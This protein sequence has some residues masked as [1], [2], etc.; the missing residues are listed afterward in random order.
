MWFGALG[1]LLVRSDDGLEVEVG[2]RQR[3][4]L[5]CHLLVD[6]NRVVSADQLIDA[7]W[8]ENPPQA[9]TGSLQAQLSRLRSTLGEGVLKTRPPGYVLTIPD[10][11]FDVTQFEHLTAEGRRAAANRQIEEA[12]EKLGQGLGLWRGDAY[13]E[14]ADLEFARAEAARLQE[15][16]VGALE[17]RISADLGL[18]RHLALVPE[19]EALIDK[20]RFRE[21]F[22][23]RLMLALYRSGRQADA[24]SVYQQTR[25]IL[26]EELGIEPSAELRQ[27]EEQILLQ[28]PVLTGPLAAT[29]SRGPSQTGVT[30]FLFADVQGSTGVLERLGTERY[31]ML[32]DDYRRIVKEAAHSEKGWIVNTEGDGIFCAFGTASSALKAAAI[33]QTAITQHRWP[34][35]VG[36]QVRMGIH[37]GEALETPNDYVS[38]EVHRAARIAQAAWGGQILLSQTTHDLAAEL[39]STGPIRDRELGEHQLKD[40]TVPIRL[41]QLE[42]P[43]LPTDH[44]SPRS[45]QTGRHN[46]PA[47]LTSFIGR[48]QELAELAKLVAGARLVT[49]TGV[50]GSGKTRLALEAAGAAVGEFPDGVKLIQLAPIGSADLVVPAV[51]DSMGVQAQAHQPLIETLAQHVRTKEMLLIV[52]NC[53]HLLKPAADTVKTLLEAAPG[54]RILATSRQRL[55]V[56]GEVTYPLHPMPIPAADIVELKQLMRVEAVALFASRAETAR[57]GFRITTDNASAIKEICRH[58]DGIPLAI[59]LAAGRLGSL[60]PQKIA[61]HLDQR[62]RI[63]TVADRTAP[64][65]QQTLRATID[66][67]YQLLSQTEQTLFS[68]LSIFRGSFP[69]EAAEE[70][71]KDTQLSPLD[72]VDL[73]PALAENSLVTVDHTP[74]ATRY[75]LLETIREYAT[76][77]L[78]A[79]GESDQLQHRHA[80]FFVKLA[81]ESEPHLRTAKQHETAESFEIETD[82]FRQ[83]LEWAID[84]NQTETAHRLAGALWRFWL[85]QNHTIEGNKWMKT[86]LALDGSVPDS[87]RAK[88]LHGAGTMASEQFQ[89]ADAI[90]YLQQAAEIYRR[91]GG[92]GG[93]QLELGAVLN[94]LGVIFHWHLGELD[95][96][97]PVYQEALGLFRLTNQWGVAVALGN[98]GSLALHK[99]DIETARHLIEENLRIAHE[100]GP[101]RLGS[102]YDI[103][104]DLHIELGD[105]NAAIKDLENSA[106]NYDAEGG[107][108]DASFA[109]ARLAYP[110]LENGN[111]DR[112]I[113]LFIPNATA[114]LA[115]PEYQ[116]RVGHITDLAI[117]RV[118]IDLATRRT[119]RAALLMGAID[120]MVDEGARNPSSTK[121]LGRYR[122]TTRRLLDPETLE[123]AMARGAA[124]SLDDIRS[125]ITEPFSPT[126][127]VSS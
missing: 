98:L 126:V 59:E 33:A 66:W 25:K 47:R 49:I 62:L 26:G 102:A 79:A 7:L 10:D 43:D 108:T 67:S 92:A 35:D 15:L 93:Y 71:C 97:E 121:L 29:R 11:A 53:E 57:P 13:A 103:L 3:R 30:T 38:L 87:V 94:N 125:L 54:L 65:H 23:A 89:Q 22:T 19:L 80:A 8:R 90:S 58:L 37:T 5:L 75:R 95:R 1:P 113:E 56:V 41:Y 36:L 48:T 70:I 34:D 2:P 63:L 117:I 21:G 76:E 101:L 39:L 69:L 81:E 31:A 104:S 124:R 32:L 46:L 100:L 72:V 17:D 12:A 50:G 82:N 77:Q 105:I 88:V 78:A 123:K 68:R 27:L 116:A 40:L 91:L 107:H 112:A 83:T 4:I 6:T 64:P 16:R 120:R 110:L 85:D 114:V 42:A 61:S 18:G 109:R 74:V 14:F 119:E 86:I 111:T 60:S 127:A 96:A 99:G 45:F 118:G 55:T 73:L 44:R 24:L 122:E 84:T 52:D 106:E 115:D 9:A 20:Y 51:A 28:D